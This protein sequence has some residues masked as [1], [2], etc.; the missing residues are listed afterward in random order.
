MI[1]VKFPM[2]DGRILHTRYA[3]KE[4][5]FLGSRVKSQFLEL[6]QTQ[7]I[8]IGVETLVSIFRYASWFRISTHGWW[9]EIR[10]RPVEQLIL[11]YLWRVMNKKAV[12]Q[13][14]FFKLTKLESRVKPVQNFCG[15][16]SI[17]KFF[18]YYALKDTSCHFVPY[19]QCVLKTI[20]NT[21]SNHVVHPFLKPVELHNLF[22]LVDIWFTKLSASLP[23]S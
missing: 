1:S 9:V 13:E 2:T 18:T 14:C 4:L 20:K 15:Y 8:E 21:V 10:N 23:K 22:V 17:P 12:L 16:R 5:P 11:Y 6:T 7:L 19:Q 3:R